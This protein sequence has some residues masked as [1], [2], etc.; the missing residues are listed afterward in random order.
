MIDPPP[1]VQLSLTDFNP[2]C[3]EDI[4]ELQYPFHIMHC[5]L[6]SASPASTATQS[7]PTSTP[8]SSTGSPS[9]SDVTAVTDPDQTD[10][11][12]R[13]LMGTLVASPFA[14]TDP[15]IPEANPKQSRLGTFFIFP[16]LSCRQNGLYRLRFTLMKVDMS[17][18]AAEGGQ[19]HVCG[20]IDSDIFT[21]FSAKD[22]PGM[23]ASSRLIRELK[24]QG[25]PVS[26]RKG[27]DRGRSKKE[28]AEK[29]A[30]SVSG[31]ADDEDEVD[32]G[33]RT[34]KKRA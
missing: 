22:F 8:Q 14:G 2:A 15:E 17:Q 1:I 13:R 33:P 30:S 27:K 28:A 11:V 9:S 19:G 16:D 31:S 3:K 29:R 5:A 32:K 18:D 7:R 34:R 6:L 4:A 25:A 21:V 23:T 12:S 24:K 26:V 10:R 20:S